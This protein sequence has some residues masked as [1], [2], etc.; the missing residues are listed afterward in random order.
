[1][2]VHLTATPPNR[3]KER[4]NEWERFG[5]VA[6]RKVITG[7]RIKSLSYFC[8]EIRDNPPEDRNIRFPPKFWIYL[9]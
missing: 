3:L 8:K 1:M 2:I 9:K 4:V 5:G 6:N 7:F